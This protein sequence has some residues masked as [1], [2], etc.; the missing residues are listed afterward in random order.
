MQ[1]VLNDL[2]DHLTTLAS[3]TCRQFAWAPDGNH[4]LYSAGS[5]FT[6]YNLSNGSSFSLSAEDGSVPYWSP[7]SQFLLLDGPH[8]LALIE[9]K[10]RQQQLLLRDAN[11]ASTVSTPASQPAPTAN[12]NDLLQPVANN[13]WAADNHHFL[14]SPRGQ[15]FWQGKPL[16]SGRGLYTVAVDNMGQLQGPPVLVDTG[17]DIQAGW[18][19]EDPNTSFL[20]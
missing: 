6:I 4:I 16:G 8:T 19:Y 15:L 13:V 17:R 11:T 14:F 20:F 18:S 3:C 7:D 12:V 5:T 9:V 10:N 2:H 1:L